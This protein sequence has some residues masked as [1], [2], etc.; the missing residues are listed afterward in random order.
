METYGEFSLEGCI[1]MAW[2]MGYIRHHNGP[3]NGSQYSGWIDSE[4][5]KPVKDSEIKKIY[6]PR[7]LEHSGIRFIGI[8]SY[9]QI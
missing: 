6:E 3:L 9:I 2:L 1:E 4:S 5:K 8:I 7:I